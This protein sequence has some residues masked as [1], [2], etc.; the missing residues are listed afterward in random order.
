MPMRTYMETLVSATTAGSARTAAARASAI[1]AA[2]IFPL[3][4]NYI[5]R[6]GQQLLLKAS[7]KISCVVTTPGTARYDINFLDSAAVN[8]IVFDSLAM[9][10]NIVAKTD[11][12][13]YMEILLT[14]MA[15]GATANFMIA[16]YWFSAAAVNTAAIAT[17]PGPGGFLFPFNTAPVVGA[18]FD[19][20]LAQTVDLQFTQT[21]ATGS[22]TLQQYSLVSMN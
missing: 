15:V 19:S 1:P 12:P 20:R 17:G 6:I 10:L 13:W 21:V 4:P 7:G 11:T 8:A 18:N 14:A 3:E 2:A 9:S 16:G 5:N 22:M